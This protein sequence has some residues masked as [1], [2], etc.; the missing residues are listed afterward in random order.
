MLGAVGN[1][2]LSLNFSCLDR[3][4]SA[5][6]S[7]SRHSDDGTISSCKSRYVK[8]TTHKLPASRI[9]H[10]GAVAQYV[11][12]ASQR[13]GSMVLPMLEPFRASMAVAIPMALMV[14][15]RGCLWGVLQH[16]PTL[17]MLLN[18]LHPSGYFFPHSTGFRNTTTVQSLFRLILR[19]CYT[20]FSSL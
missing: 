3:L 9:A 2:E 19:H 16:L 14:G 1:W 12:Q 18:A 8:F 17:A 20:D 6:I 11:L 4:I 7:T 10:M 13:T 15:G 5:R